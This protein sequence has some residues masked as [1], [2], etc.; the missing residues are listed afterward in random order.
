MN[1]IAFNFVCM[2]LSSSGTKISRAN[3]PGYHVIKSS[4]CITAVWLRKILV[5]SQQILC[6]YFFFVVKNDQPLTQFVCMLNKQKR[7]RAVLCVLW[8]TC[9]FL[10]RLWQEGSVL[11]GKRYSEGIRRPV[12]RKPRAFVS[13]PESWE[14]CS[15]WICGASS[16]RRT[17]AE[18][19]HRHRRALQTGAAQDQNS[20]TFT[21]KWLKEDLGTLQ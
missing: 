9:M 10:C 5:A 1:A 7:G 14:G 3:S 20:S 13:R 12:C 16:G 2:L 15:S 19:L 21:R 8:I 17:E 4:S 11:A 18:I 6:M